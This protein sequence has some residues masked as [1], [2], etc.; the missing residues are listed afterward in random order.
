[1]LFGPLFFTFNEMF[2]QKLLNL[3]NYLN[4]P[5]L[6]SN[7][8]KYFGIIVLLP[9][10]KKGNEDEKV[11]KQKHN[12]RIKSILFGQIAS[13]SSNF[14]AH[15]NFTSSEPLSYQ[16]KYKFWFYFFSFG[17][18]LGYEC[19][20]SLFFPF[21]FWNYDQTVA[22]KIVT[23]WVTLMYVGQAI[24]DIVKWPRPSSPPVVSL[25]PKYA[26]EY[27]MPSTHAIIGLGIPFSIVIFS[28]NRFEA[29][30]NFLLSFFYKLNLLSF[31]ILI[32]SLIFGMV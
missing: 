26:I 12:P 19:F 5:Y 9:S 29:S 30:F 21:M 10:D 25:E 11:S 13:T 28:S 22:Q 8:Q 3:I 18:S 15:Q 31:I 32:H 7:F 27:G 6:V 23:V 17:A 4:D 2:Y 16:L 14:K 20:Y 24:K 1:M